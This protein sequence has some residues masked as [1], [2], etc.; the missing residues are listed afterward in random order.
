MRKTEE[1]GFVR[2]AL[3]GR[4]GYLVDSYL[5]LKY[6]YAPFLLAVIVVTLCASCAIPK[7]MARETRRIGG[8][9]SMQVSI[10]DD[11]NLNQPIAVDLVLV[12]DNDLLKQFSQLPATAWFEKRD[13][14]MR[15]HEK[16]VQ[17]V[18]WEW[19]PGQV[20]SEVE[21]KIDPSITGAVLFARYSTPG[22]HRAVLSSFGPSQLSLDK[23]DFSYQPRK[24]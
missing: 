17:L 10:A 1:A 2:S 24:G 19:V 9:F 8:H 14:L 7:R 6:V 18:S 11:A 5:L 22:D 13:Q 15:D 21:L 16:K 20:V 3:T 23:E 12:K 4:R